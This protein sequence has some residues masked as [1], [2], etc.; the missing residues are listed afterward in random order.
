MILF[1]PFKLSD[2]RFDAIHQSILHFPNAC[3]DGVNCV[4]DNFW[5]KLM[6]I[7]NKPV[8]LKNTTVI[9][10]NNRLSKNIFELSLD[11]LGVPCIVLGKEIPIENWDN[12]VK[13]ELTL[14]ALEDIHTE[15]VLGVDAFDA[16]MVGNP[17]NKLSL[18][19]NCDLLFNTSD[20]SLVYIHDVDMLCDKNF[21]QHVYRYLNAG[22]WMGKC[23]FCKEF[24]T[25]VASLNFLVE[26]LI[27]EVPNHLVDYYCRSEQ[28]RIK[29]A[30][31][32]FFPRAYLDCNRELFWCVTPKYL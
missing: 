25:Y 22:A 23:E 24:F 10:W 14:R 12:K 9:T 20:T 1:D 26:Q 18:L 30:F 28:V 16:L 32:H 3:G 27:P 11:N 21:S 31:P 6:K 4:L 8:V 13:I 7:F 17:E 2:F 15:F 19:E 29:L 5:S